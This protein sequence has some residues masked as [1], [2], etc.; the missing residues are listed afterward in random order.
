MYF[1]SSSYNQQSTPS[2]LPHNSWSWRFCLSKLKT[3]QLLTQISLD[4]FASSPLHLVWIDLRWLFELAGMAGWLIDHGLRKWCN[5]CIL[6]EQKSKYIDKRQFLN[7][8]HSLIM[9]VLM[10]SEELLM[11]VSRQFIGCWWLPLTPSHQ[12]PPATSNQETSNIFYVLRFSRQT[13]V[14][15]DIQWW[16]TIKC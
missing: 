3:Q 6:M 1:L 13:S 8:T 15:V 11:P 4:S 14:F 12:E 16:I 7:S 9:K 2:L 10:E 5:Q